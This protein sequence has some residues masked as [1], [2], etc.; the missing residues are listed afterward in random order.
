MSQNISQYESDVWKTAD[1]LIGAGIKQSDFPK[2]MM[3]FFAILR[4][5]RKSYFSKYIYYYFSEKLKLI[6]DILAQGSTNQTELQKDWLLAFFIC[7]PPQ[8]EQVA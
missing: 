1:L 2:F 5:T 8:A 3:P 7:I 4:D 6:N